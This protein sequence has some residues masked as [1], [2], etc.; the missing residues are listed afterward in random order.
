MGEILWL[1][2][3][4]NI[5]CWFPSLN[6]GIKE[7]LVCVVKSIAWIVDCHSPVGVHSTHLYVMFVKFS[8]FFGFVIIRYRRMGGTS[9]NLL[10]QLLR[11]SRSNQLGHPWGHVV[12]GSPDS[13]DYHH[14]WYANV[15]IILIVIVMMI[16][17][18]KYLHSFPSH[19]SQANHRYLWQSSAF[20]F[21][22]RWRWQ[23]LTF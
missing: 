1:F 7:I 13:D 2:D 23:T 22:S 14:P 4:E 15:I 21:W 8:H 6:F 12:V 17:F 5:L 20:R 3:T 19:Q 18:V 11:K 10:E 16:D 9:F